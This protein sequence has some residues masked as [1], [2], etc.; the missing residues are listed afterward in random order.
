MAHAGNLYGG[1][2]GYASHAIAAPSYDYS[3]SISYAAPS[4][5]VSSVSQY[6]V[7]AAPVATYAKSYAAPIASYA[8]VSSYAHAPI[9]YD[10]A[11]ISAYAHAPI[12][13]YAHAA[14]V[15]YAAAPIAHNLGGY[16]SIQGYGYDSYGYGSGLG[17]G[18]KY[19]W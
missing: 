19:G 8:P 6:S 7:H 1:S 14:P 3:P 17:Y 18:G 16:G 5:A 10:H 2:L 15:A 9:S 4:H 13:S 11:P 12:S